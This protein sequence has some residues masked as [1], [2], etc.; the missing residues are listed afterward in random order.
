MTSWATG[1]GKIFDFGSIKEPC[2]FLLYAVSH[3][4]YFRGISKHHFCTARGFCQHTGIF[5][6]NR[7][8]WLHSMKTPADKWHF[9]WPNHTRRVINYGKCTLSTASHKIRLELSAFFEQQLYQTQGGMTRLTWP[10][11]GTW[12]EKNAFP[13]FYKNKLFRG[14]FY[15]NQHFLMLV[16][17]VW[18]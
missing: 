12:K 4:K 10:R 17:G 3:L 18:F 11:E 6:A 9:H 7:F 13:F 16:F 15:N 2:S 1:R 8:Y 5:D 14:S